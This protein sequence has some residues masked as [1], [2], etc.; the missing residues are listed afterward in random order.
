MS[1]ILLLNQ[2]PLLSS[3]HLNLPSQHQPLPFHP[4]DRACFTHSSDRLS[5]RFW[6]LWI[7]YRSCAVLTRL[8]VIRSLI[9][10]R[11]LGLPTPTLSFSLPLILLVPLSYSS[12]S[13][14]PTSIESSH[15][16]T[17]YTT[18]YAHEILNAISKD[19]IPYAPPPSKEARKTRVVRVLWENKSCAGTLGPRFRKRDGWRAVGFWGFGYKFSERCAEG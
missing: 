8:F 4:A 13:C 6:R 5:W 19:T 9:P 3:L 18:I 1:V 7:Q 14:N 12:I 15:S 10:H 16:R 11:R 17:Q 2:T